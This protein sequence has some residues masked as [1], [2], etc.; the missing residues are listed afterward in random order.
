M[1]KK[2]VTKNSST[3]FSDIY[4]DPEHYFYA[5]NGAILK[6]LRDLSRFL[7][8]VDEE[9]FRHHVIR[10]KKNDFSKWVIDAYADESLAKKIDRCESTEAMRRAIENKLSKYAIT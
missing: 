8:M 1:Q 10:G 4:L 9:T 6:D 3:S 2:K 7:N 5:C